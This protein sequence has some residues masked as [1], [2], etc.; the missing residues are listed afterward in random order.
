MIRICARFGCIYF[1]DIFWYLFLWYQVTNL[2]SDSSYLSSK[3]V[4]P[5]RLRPSSTSVLLD[6]LQKY[7]VS[8]N[9]FVRY[10][11][12]IVFRKTACTKCEKPQ[13]ISRENF[14][15][16]RAFFVFDSSW[17]L[18]LQT[19]QFYSV[20][21]SQLSQLYFPIIWSLGVIILI[22][23]HTRPGCQWMV[24]FWNIISR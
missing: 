13:N 11:Y 4:V 15:W 10:L 22:D 12:S 1:Y 21:L 9:K 3:S 23:T 5:F 7:N 17:L 6:S 24:F 8:V 2:C 19:N 16:K 20:Y 18:S 14:S